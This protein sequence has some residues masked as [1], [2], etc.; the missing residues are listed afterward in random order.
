MQ[1]ALAAKDQ[2]MEARLAEQS[3]INEEKMHQMLAA[4][5]ASQG[6]AAPA[7]LPTRSP[8]TPVSFQITSKHRH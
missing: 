4:Y 6:F 1:A 5:C 2:E 7:P 8:H 3:R